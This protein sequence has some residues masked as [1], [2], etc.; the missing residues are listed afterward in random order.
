MSNS[1]LRNSKANENSNEEG[2]KKMENQ[3]KYMY[4]INQASKYF[5]IGV[6]TL[7]KMIKQNQDA[8]YIFKVGNRVL[9]KKNLFMEFLNT[10]TSAF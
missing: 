5:N 8:V 2:G 3:E 1:N 9:I 4:T 6:H 7:R 10:N